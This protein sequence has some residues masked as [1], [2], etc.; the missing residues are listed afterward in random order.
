MRFQFT[1]APAAPGRQLGGSS[2]DWPGNP[3]NG[4]ALAKAYAKRLW[5]AGTI[6]SAGD[7]TIQIYIND[8]LIATNKD[9]VLKDGATGDPLCGHTSAYVEGKAGVLNNARAVSYTHLPL[10]TLY[11]L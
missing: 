8:V 10:P 1:D 4:A 5:V 7:L 3:H 11:S 2:F 6:A 9:G